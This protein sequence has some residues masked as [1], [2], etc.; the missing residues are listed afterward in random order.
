MKGLKARVTGDALATK[1]DAIKRL[2]ALPLKKKIDMA[3]E[4]IEKSKEHRRENSRAC[5]CFSGGK[6]SCTVLSLL[7]RVFPR[8]EIVCNYNPTLLMAPGRLE[9]IKSF[10]EKEGVEFIATEPVDVF[11]MWQETGYYPI[12]PKRSQSKMGK[13][14][15][16]KCGPVQCCYRQKEAPFLKFVKDWAINLTY[17]GNRASESTRRLFLAVDT[18]PIALSQRG[19]YNIYPILYWTLGDVLKYIAKNIPWFEGHKAAYNEDC[20]ACATDIGCFPNNLYRLLQ[21]DPE[22]FKKVMRA[23]F[24]EQMLKANKQPPEKLE[25]FLEHNPEKLCIIEGVTQGKRRAR[26]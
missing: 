10:A 6:D 2:Q 23:G 18:P 20:V 25:H 26:S 8:S 12:F 17:W 15:G 9:K 19:R 5:C 21:R 16:I 13:R 7:C 4:I 22:T 1:L 14:Y 11:A 24:G 3:L